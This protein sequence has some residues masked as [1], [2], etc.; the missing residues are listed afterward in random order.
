MDGFLYDK[1]MKE[2]N[3]F[4]PSVAFHIKT[5]YLM[6]CENQMAGV[7]MKCNAWLKKWVKT[8]VLLL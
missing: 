2:L 5:I 6:Y 8:E 1:V 4:Q 7:Y 3:P